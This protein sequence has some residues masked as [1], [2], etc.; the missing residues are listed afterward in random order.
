[1]L[2]NRS[3][4]GFTARSDKRPHQTPRDPNRTRTATEYETATR[5]STVEGSPRAAARQPAWTHRSR[6]HPPA[7]PSARA[8]AGPTEPPAERPAKRRSAAPPRVRTQSQ[9]SPPPRRDPRGHPRAPDGPPRARR[10]HGSSRRPNRQGTAGRRRRRRSLHCR[11]GEATHTHQRSAVVSHGPP[12]VAAACL[13]RSAQSTGPERFPKSRAATGASLGPQ[14]NTEPESVLTHRTGLHSET[15]A[16]VCGPARRNARPANP[17]TSKRASRL[18][19][20]GVQPLGMARASRVDADWGTSFPMFTVGVDPL[21]G[22][23]RLPVL[24]WETTYPSPCHTRSPRWGSKAR[25]M[26]SG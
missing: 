5:A 19:W 10:R 1:M 17:T 6:P 20:C 25:A 2:P 13:P 24:T 4:A 8:A 15:P 23:S 14:Q 3:T 18:G 21:K 12:R 11:N 7:P 22:S 9:A 26:P 16:A